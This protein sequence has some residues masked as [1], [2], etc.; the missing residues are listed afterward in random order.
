VQSGVPV[1]EKKEGSDCPV[2]W[3]LER[4]SEG[5]FKCC[6]AMQASERKAL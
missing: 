5:R 1:P 3:L 4:G 2:L 6:H